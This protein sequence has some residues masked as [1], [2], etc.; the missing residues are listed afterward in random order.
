[1]RFFFAGSL[2]PITSLPPWLA[3]VANRLTWSLPPEPIEA[4]RFIQLGP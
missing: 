3:D 1:V 4:G 2:F